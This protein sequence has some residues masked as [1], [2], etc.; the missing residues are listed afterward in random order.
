VQEVSSTVLANKAEL[1]SRET[2]NLPALRLEDDLPNRR[3]VLNDTTKPHLTN[4]QP[5]LLEERTRNVAA[6]GRVNMRRYLYP[7]PR[8]GTIDG[9]RLDNHR[10]L[11]ATASGRR[12]A[13][14]ADV[15]RD[16]PLPTPRLQP[17]QRDVSTANQN[18][19][20]GFPR[21]LPRELITAAQ[22]ELELAPLRGLNTKQNSIADRLA[23]RL[24]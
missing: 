3:V 19:L 20:R 6:H 5:S 17:L 23:T 15:L 8:R 2:L 10:T 9:A 12:P 21:Y 11:A 22:Q 13:P 4:L 24:P 1:A 7:L 18:P 14:E 16:T